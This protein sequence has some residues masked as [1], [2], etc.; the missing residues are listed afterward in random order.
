[1]EYYLLPRK[2]WA[3]IRKK[4]RK[5]RKER[6]MAG[7]QTKSPQLR[8]QPALLGQ[9]KSYSLENLLCDWEALNMLEK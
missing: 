2:I 7:N 9:V 6:G 3:S 8:T 4:G 5:E 1:L